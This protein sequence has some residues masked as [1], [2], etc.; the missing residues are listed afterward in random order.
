[1]PPGSRR[2]RDSLAEAVSK[3]PSDFHRSDINEIGRFLHRFWC[4]RNQPIIEHP[5]TAA[6]DAWLA[7]GGAAGPVAPEPLSKGEPLEGVG[8]VIAAVRSDIVT[9][10]SPADMIGSRLDRAARADKS[11]VAAPSALASWSPRTLAPGWRRRCVLAPTLYPTALRPQTRCSGLPEAVP[12][13][14]V[15]GGGSRPW[16]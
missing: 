14:S 7:E 13:P 6:P 16:M 3:N 4:V 2:G 9:A 12:P 8:G 10:M 5:K 11:E 15:A 1:M